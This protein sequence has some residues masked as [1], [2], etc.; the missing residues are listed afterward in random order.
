MLPQILDLALQRPHLPVGLLTLGVEQRLELR[1]Q[2]FVVVAVVGASVAERADRG[3]DKSST[4]C[5]NAAERGGV[6]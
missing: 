2:G 4:A 6:R 1:E 5:S 3:G